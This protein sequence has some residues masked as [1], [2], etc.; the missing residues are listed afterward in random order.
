VDITFVVPH[1]YGDE[2]TPHMNL[3][4]PNFIPSSGHESTEDR[5]NSDVLTTSGS[6]RTHLLGEAITEMEAG[7]CRVVFPAFLMPYWTE[8]E[9]E[10]RREYAVQTS[11]S[12][13]GE[14]FEETEWV[15]GAASGG[16]GAF[17]TQEESS[18][19]QYGTDIFDEVARYTR[20]VV[21]T[22]AD[23]SF[24]LIHAHDWM[25]YAAGMA[26]AEITG[27]PL[28]VHAHSLEYDRSGANVNPRID[29]IERR[30]LSR[31]DAVLPVSHY[32]EC[33]LHKNYG[34]PLDR[35]H[36][37]HNG[38]YIPEAIH[39]Y[40]RKRR[41]WPEN[42]V[43]FLG[44]ITYQKGPEYFVR[45]AAKVVRHVP[46]VLFVMAGSGDMLAGMIDLTRELGLEEHFHFPGFLRGKEVEEIFSVAALYV[47]P[48]VSEPFGISALEAVNFDIPA[49]ISKQSG[50]SEVVRGALKVDFWDVDRLADLMI[51]GLLHEE[52]REDLIAMAREELKGIHWDASA[53]KTVEAYN[54]VLQQRR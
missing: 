19:A 7:V 8:E 25:T 14:V 52:L 51:N 46:D 29:A 22:M 4:S 43:L 15:E 42:V 10:E 37:V 39:H 47:M 1:V 41:D 17:V 44:R 3:A 16:V 40:K 31:A 48:S 36:V 21:E 12:I 50:V 2:E 18:G 30:G 27:K 9:Y 34:V 33:I 11:R 49:I 54:C 32:T 35:I 53:A 6:V 5:P 38:I 45:A 26:L 28:V 13:D 24:D 23:E 20:A